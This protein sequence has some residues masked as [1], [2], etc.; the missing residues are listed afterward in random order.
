M[1][2]LRQKI[3]LSGLIVLV[4]LFADAAK[5]QMV[6]YGTVQDSSQ[7]KIPYCLVMVLDKNNSEIV[8]TMTDSTGYFETNIS[9]QTKNLQLYIRAFGFKALQIPV[10]QATTQTLYVLSR[11]VTTLDPVSITASQITM[12]RQIGRFVIINVYTS[13]LA[14]GNNITEVLKYVPLVNVTDDDELEI[15]RKGKAT[16]YIN[17]RKSNID[18]KNIPAENIEKIEI[19]SSPGSEYPATERAGVINIILRKSLEDGSVTNITVEDKQNDKW[20]LNSP[21]FRLFSMI[22]KKKVNATIGFSTG[23]HPMFS[24]SFGRYKY[25]SEN[26]GRDQIQQYKYANFYSNLNCSLDWHISKK[27]TLGF[28]IDVDVYNTW[29]RSHTTTEYCTLF[30]S[31]TDSTDHTASNTSMRIPGLMLSMNINDNIQ[32]NEKQLLSFDF[33]YTRDFDKIPYFYQYEKGNYHDPLLFYRTETKMIIDGYVFKSKY[34]YAHSDELQWSVGLDC[35][36][37]VADDDFYYGL[38]NNNYYIEDSSKSNHFIYN[39]FTAALYANV[40]WEISDEWNL[41][42]GLRGEYYTFMGLQK[43]TGE[44]N[45]GKYPNIFPSLSLSYLPSDDHE[46]GLD[47]TSEIC[48][49]GYGQRNPFKYYYSPTLYKANDPYLR[50]TKGYDLQLS[51]TLFSDYMFMFNYFCSIDNWETFHI[52]EENGVT[53]I[54]TLNFGNDHNFSASFFINKDLFKDYLSLSLSAGYIYTIFRNLG[55]GLLYNTDRSSEFYANANISTAM[56]RKKTWR[57]STTFNY[58]SPCNSVSKHLSE[59]YFLSAEI[60]KRFKRSKLSFGVRNILDWSIHSSL[61]TPEYTYENKSRN[62]R[63]TYWVSYSFKFGN[64]KSKG[65]SSRDGNNIQDRL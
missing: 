5:A 34:D 62:F 24:E 25:I 30:P 31:T 49:P 22:Q 65:A 33:Y 55:E 59:G 48:L 17:G 35:Y 61:F 37:S 56:D 26:V 11:E 1:N 2:T 29:S 21:T 42:A 51:Y 3:N 52:P 43:S 45:Y 18:P 27:N 12:E 58:S 64:E 14:A 38:G 6:L 40:D 23:Y 63:R 8:S 47:F 39:D 54:T 15:L 53:R 50:P 60:S 28:Q 32:I 36:G 19:I 44:K 10:E 4:L 57:F 46:L 41:S 16:I 7:Q 13:P 20:F 9:S